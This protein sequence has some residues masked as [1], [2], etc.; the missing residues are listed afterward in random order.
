M[1]G[2]FGYFHI[3]P[4]LTTLTIIL[5]L[6]YNQT[7]NPLGFFP[8]KFLRKLFLK[9]KDDLSKIILQGACIELETDFTLKLFIKNFGISVV[10]R[11]LL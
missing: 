1:I 2:V 7:C 4:S 10:D 5:K 8:V 11:Q 3:N 9:Y 6:L